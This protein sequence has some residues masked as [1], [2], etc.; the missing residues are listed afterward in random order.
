MTGMQK[1]GDDYEL[2]CNLIKSMLNGCTQEPIQLGSFE[3]AKYVVNTAEA[4]VWLMDNEIDFEFEQIG[5]DAWT[6]YKDGYEYLIEMSGSSS[7]PTYKVF[8]KKDGEERQ[9]I[10]YK[11]LLDKAKLLAE[12]DYYNKVK[13]K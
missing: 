9:Y 7:K 12:E 3:L 2:E 13:E 1:Y 11:F 8:I 10:G 6:C 4:I 5:E